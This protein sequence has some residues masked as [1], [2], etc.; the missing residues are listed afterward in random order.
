MVNLPYQFENQQILNYV[1]DSSLYALKTSAQL[2]G[3][4]I[5]IDNPS[6]VAYGDSGSVDAFGRLRVSN[7]LTLFDS[8]QIFY[9]DALATSTENAPLFYDNAQTAGTGTSTLF[10]LAKAQTVLSVATST[11][12]T[13]VRQSKMRFNYQPGKSMLIFMTFLMGSTAPGI[14]KREGLFDANNGLYLENDGTGYYLVRRTKTSGN[15]ENN[16][17]AQA[18]WNVDPMDGNGPS[19]ITIDFTKTQILVFDLE[20]LGVGRVRMGF[21]ID[22]KIYYVHYFNHANVLD[23]VYM[24]TPN[25]PL[26]SEISNDGTGLTD[27]LTQICS[28]V[29]SEGGMSD[30]GVIRSA[31]TN[32]S[33]VDCDA[34]NT[35]YAILGMKINSNY[36]GMHVD[37]LNIALQIQTASHR[38]EWM[39]LLNPTVAD[40]FSYV[41]E[42][43]SAIEVARGATANTVTGGIKFSNGF[44]ESGGV[45]SGG[46]GSADRGISNAI[47]LGNKIDGTADTLVLCFR[48][49]GGSSNVDVEGMITWRELS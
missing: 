36:V 30:L 38:G 17:V 46:A 42:T 41:R 29:I 32:G 25:L 8:K 34:E 15:V 1:Y 21:V 24:S 23:V 39:L 49:I 2:N 22:G 12:G 5:S 40:S 37:I 11:I 20:W 48:P 16:R 9:D 26:R 33:H 45:A 7:P 44:V 35:I 47:R 13:R 6:F 31:S 3:S 28:T 19:G 27:N 43:N 10:Q 18:S 14:T 4:T